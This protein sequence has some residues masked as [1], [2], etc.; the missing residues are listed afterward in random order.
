MDQT[1]AV[2]NEKETAGAS[3]VQPEDSRPFVS[4]FMS[5]Y[6]GGE[7][8]KKA[9]DSVL[10]QTYNHFE[11]VI[12]NDGSTD[13]TADYLNSLDD[14]RI[15]VIH[16]ENQGLGKPLNKWMK[17]CK[18]KYVMRLDA[19]DICHETRMEKQVAFLEEN[20]DVILVGCQVQMFSDRGMGAVS[21]LFTDHEDILNGMLNGWHTQSHPTIMWRRTLLDHMPG[22]AFSGAGEDWSFLLDAARFGKLANHPDVLYYYRLHESSN[23][24][25]GAKRVQAGLN[26]AIRR[27]E[28]FEKT[29]QEYPLEKFM[30]EWESR[31]FP[32][33]VY[34]E[35]QA[36]SAV[37][38][39]KAMLRNMEGKKMGY[40]WRLGMAA[41]LDPS[42]TLGAVKKKLHRKRQV[43]D[44][45]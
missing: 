33:T 3:E 17:T 31:P 4:V 11:F 27:Y 15:T 40:L 30:E 39:R 1:T 8:L 32:K 26:Y 45:P 19:D 18:G 9:V 24:W 23:A 36:M 21:S 38:F 7:Y 22:Y 34:T 14:K 25:K 44:T 43:Q 42:K 29:G 20:P 6:N 28:H 10:N 37:L 12:V 5:V 41:V 13:D 2:L 16:Q 35:L